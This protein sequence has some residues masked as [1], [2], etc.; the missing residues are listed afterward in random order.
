VKTKLSFETLES[1]RALS[2][3][4]VVSSQR[5]PQAAQVR[6]V[7]N[8]PVLNLPQFVGTYQGAGSL[9]GI[10]VSGSENTRP[11]IAIATGG[12]GTITGKVDR[13][14]VFQTVRN[15]NGGVTVYLEGS[16]S[17][18]NRNMRNLTYH[19]NDAGIR[20]ALFIRNPTGCTRL[21]CL[22]VPIRKF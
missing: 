22:Y 16:P 18:V 8:R 4:S 13:C 10:T 15:P 2:A 9:G 19:G 21:A 14:V 11:I 1:K 3:V 5:A 12:G 20:A 6:V 17:A 7:D